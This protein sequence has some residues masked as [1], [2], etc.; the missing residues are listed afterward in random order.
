MLLQ[1]RNGKPSP[2]PP[3]LFPCFHIY[4]LLYINLVITCKLVFI[5]II[6]NYLTVLIIFRFGL[7]CKQNLRSEFFSRN[8]FSG[9]AC[10]NICYSGI[11]NEQCEKNVH[12]PPPPSPPLRPLYANLSWY[13]A[14]AL[15]NMLIRRR[16]FVSSRY[17]VLSVLLHACRLF[18][19]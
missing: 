16:R 10:I 11:L 19:A 2:P 3:L 15:G 18:L 6:Q 12:R 5:L 1:S 13:K 17:S 9:K 7:P 8:E 14:C 4:Y